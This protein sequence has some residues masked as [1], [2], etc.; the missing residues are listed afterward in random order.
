[1]SSDRPVVSGLPSGGGLT[2]SSGNDSHVRRL[3]RMAEIDRSSSGARIRFYVEAGKAWQAR[4]VVVDRQRGVVAE[5]D[6][7]K[8][9]QDYVKERNHA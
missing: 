9:A 4:W 1:M 7:R 3:V 5:F 2:L 6:R 8:D